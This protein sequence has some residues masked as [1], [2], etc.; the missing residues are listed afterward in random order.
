MVLRRQSSI[1][2]L[3]RQIKNIITTAKLKS[4]YGKEV[5]FLLPYDTTDRYPILF[6][7]L[8][9]NV[10]LKKKALVESYGISMPTLEEV[11]FL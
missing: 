6:E 8:D 10:A 3:K 7:F 4:H 2:E 1:E 5:S 9:Q 11:S